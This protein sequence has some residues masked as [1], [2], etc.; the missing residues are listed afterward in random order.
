MLDEE[1]SQI[2]AEDVSKIINETIE[3]VIGPA[4]FNSSKSKQWNKAIVHEILNSLSKLDLKHKFLVSCI[5]NQSAGGPGLSSACSCFF[6]EV[7]DAIVT[8]R[9]N[10]SSLYCIVTVF[11]IST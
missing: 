1:F 9:W 2:I 5:I 3:K 10:N 4:I 8:E 7:T 6:N 11:G